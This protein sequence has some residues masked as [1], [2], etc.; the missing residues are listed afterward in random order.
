MSKIVYADFNLPPIASD[1]RLSIKM[2]FSEQ[3]SWRWYVSVVLLVLAFADL[4]VPGLCRSESG[5]VQ[6]PKTATTHLSA[7][8][9]AQAPGSSSITMDGADDCWCCCSHIRPSTHFQLKTQPAVGGIETVYF[10]GAPQD[11]TSDLYHPP[12][13]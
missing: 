2:P 10:R 8:I 3:R 13:S 7:R 1:L 6:L 11:F 4:T 12:R 5:L 9:L